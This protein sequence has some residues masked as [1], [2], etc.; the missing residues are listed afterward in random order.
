MHK[1]NPWQ[2]YRQ[3]A[4]QTASPAQLVLMLYDGVIRFLEQARGGFQEEDP[5]AFN[6]TINN[7]IIRAQAIIN[8]LNYSLDMKAGQEFSTTMRG[9]YDYMDRRLQESNQRKT[10]EGIEE[11]IRRIS[12]LR[13][14]WSEMMSRAAGEASAEA[15]APTL[16]AA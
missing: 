10:P 5:L 4:T 1:L 8:E 3:I 13:D 14:A 9:L 6:Q 16:A 2:S 11:V 7:N 15:G 12:V